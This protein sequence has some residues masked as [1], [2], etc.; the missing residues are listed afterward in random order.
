MTRTV[1]LTGGCGFIGSNFVKF[2]MKHRPDWRLINLDVLSYSGNP[3]NLA[4][5][6]A[7][8]RYRF[9]RGDICDAG[10]VA[11]LMEEADCVIHMAAESH[12]DRSIMDSRP[13][14]VSNVL[15]TQTLL[16]AARRAKGGKGV[17]RFLLVSTDEVYGSLPLEQTELRF[18]EETP[19]RPNS[20]YA[21]SKAAADLMARAYHHTFGMDVVITRCS[22]N[23]GPLQFPEKVIPLFV[24]NLAEGKQVPLYGDGLNVRDWIHVDDHCEAIIRVLEA[25]RSGEVYN[26][27]G[28][29]E[30]SNLDLTHTILR[31][32]GKGPEFI[33]PVTDR[34]GHDRR[35]A[36]DNSRMQS[37][38]GWRPGRS[39]WPDALRG[40]VDWYLANRGWWERV[41]SG[42]YREYYTKQYEGPSAA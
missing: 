1:L 19:L 8:P 32:M 24:T 23:F 20:P 18:T 21:A 30:R 17:G 37:E 4:D 31:L 7:D 41:K 27:G 22:N 29:N 10:L 35:Y 28:N 26:V 5:V 3:E 42:A 16:D 36:I 12:V 14:V 6:A 25:G 34:L 33:R 2:A 39:A 15:G 40:T 13:F 9:V 38:L 11:G